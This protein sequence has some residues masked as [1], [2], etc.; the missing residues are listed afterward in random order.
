MNMGHMMR[1]RLSMIWVVLIVFFGVQIIP[2]IFVAIDAHH[3]GLILTTVRFVREG[4]LKNSDWPFNQYG[5]FWPFPY[6]LLSFLFPEN[7]TLVVIR[8]FTVLMYY[9]TAFL[10][11]KIARNFGSK[12]SA[13]LSVLLF[14][15]SEPFAAGFRTTLL[16]WPSAI[17]MI[18]TT[19]MC[20]SIIVQD[21]IVGGRF[22]LLF[23][24]TMQGALTLA[25]ILTRVQ[26]GFLV[27]VFYLLLSYFYP[28]KIRVSKYLLGIVVA[29][30]PFISFLALK[31][32]LFQSLYD[33]F[34]F[35]SSYISGDVSTYPTPKFTFIGVIL[36][37][38]FFT[39]V[40][41]AGKLN[42]TIRRIAFT[43]SSV[44]LL[45]IATLALVYVRNSRDLNFVDSITVVVR[46]LW[47]SS[48]LAIFIAY[49]LY[50]SKQFFHR[51]KT[52]VRELP[53]FKFSTLAGFSF[54]SMSQ[55][56]P[57]FDQMH[58]WWGV[59]PGVIL[60]VTFLSKLMD[61]SKFGKPN[62]LLTQLLVTLIGF[63]TVSLPL[64]LDLRQ[65]KEY[66]DTKYISYVSTTFT[67]PGKS[68]DTLQEFF[69]KNIAKGDKILNLC[70]NSNVFFDPDLG[71]SSS[72]FF[73]Y[74]PWLGNQ[75]VIS[76]DLVTSE[77]NVILT[78]TL[79]LLQG[80]I[81]ESTRQ[82]MQIV[83]SFQSRIQG[84]VSYTD[85]NVMTW[86]IYS[87]R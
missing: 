64:F 69:H 13:Y 72:R 85:S 12:N 27:L 73:V 62:V 78:C 74:W 15:I 26:I 45:M 18:I 46:R 56:F 1:N 84:Q 44:S 77:P 71:K 28:K 48:T 76:K 35:G 51:G 42:E 38:I 17:S 20:Y 53:D 5:S 31:G 86:R 25:L 67:P 32:W 70:H 82:Q 54:I 59:S 19:F 75:G 83:E 66:F 41:R 40:S 29:G 87:L 81:E 9:I 36:F 61:L 21:Q 43:S 2:R 50:L 55:V 23:S 8:T 60:I 49:L 14:F 34:I 37:L 47:I 52:G 22:R 6:A 24:P 58:F 65:P 63:S 11:F 16:P 10:I 33:E 7:L 80:R 30:V 4:L 57:L 79:N 68:E 39:F 3:D